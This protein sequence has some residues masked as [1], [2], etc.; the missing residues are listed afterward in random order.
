MVKRREVDFLPLFFVNG[1]AVVHDV[2]QQFFFFGFAPALRPGG[3]GRQSLT[4]L[5]GALS[6]AWGLPWLKSDSSECLCS[7][8]PL[9]LPIVRLLLGLFSCVLGLIKQIQRF[10]DS[11]QARP[12]SLARG[13]W[14]LG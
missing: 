10:E 3:S 8:I 14:S 1:C 7:F 4:R 6:V 2:L 5:S 11:S 9:A 12:I 13:L